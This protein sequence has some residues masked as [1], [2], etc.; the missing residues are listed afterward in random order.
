MDWL[1]KANDEQMNIVKDKKKL[2][3]KA[4]DIN[5]FRSIIQNRVMHHQDKGNKDIVK[6]LMS[7]LSA[8]SNMGRNKKNIPR[9]IID[10]IIVSRGH[11]YND[12]F[13]PL[14]G[15][16]RPNQKLEYSFTRKLIA[17]FLY[18]YSNL[19]LEIIASRYFNQ[20]SRNIKNMIKDIRFILNH[21]VVDEEIYLLDKNINDYLTT[22]YPRTDKKIKDVG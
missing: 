22:L 17:F 21:D 2:K 4:F 11:T 9:D 16:T 14:E 1:E 12:V 6:E 20:S 13:K 7:I 19:T 10:F 8:C 5:D 15:S 18:R 3:V